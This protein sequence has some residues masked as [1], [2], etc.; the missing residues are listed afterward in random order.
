M[1]INVKKIFKKMVKIVK[2]AANAK[3]RDVQI[4]QDIPIHIEGIYRINV[5][6]NPT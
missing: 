3:I 5:L 2:S 1:P 4:L 6:S